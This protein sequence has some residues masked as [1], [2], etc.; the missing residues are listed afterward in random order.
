VEELPECARYWEIRYG[1][2]GREFEWRVL[3]VWGL[4]EERRAEGVVCEGKSGI[5]FL[6]VMI[7][8][9]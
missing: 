2:L 5:D 9:R 6:Q 4:Y 1:D 3:E 8:C 7:R